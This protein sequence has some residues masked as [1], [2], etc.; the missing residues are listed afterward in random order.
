VRPTSPV[1]DTRAACALDD[2]DVLISACVKLRRRAHDAAEPDVT[3]RGI[4]RLLVHRAFGLPSPEVPLSAQSCSPRLSTRCAQGVRQLP[5]ALS[6]SPRPP[7][8]DALYCQWPKHRGAPVKYD[9][10]WIASVRSEGWC[11]VFTMAALAV[12]LTRSRR[13]RATSY[14]ATSVRDAVSV[15]QRRRPVDHLGTERS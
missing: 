6:R 1:G 11:G 14:W 9:L 10:S 2:H 13:E 5:G 4:D 8:C 7:F 15:I 3:R 12:R